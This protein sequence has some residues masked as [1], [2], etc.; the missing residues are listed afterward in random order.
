MF[1]F[2]VFFVPIGNNNYENLSS[3]SGKSIIDKGYQGSNCKVTLQL[4]SE[5]KNLKFEQNVLAK[6][7]RINCS[8]SNIFHECHCFNN[9]LGIRRLGFKVW[10]KSLTPGFALLYHFYEMIISVR[11]VD[12]W[13][14]L[15][16]THLFLF[17][18]KKVAEWS[19][20]QAGNLRVQG[21][22]SRQPLTPAL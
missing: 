21:S 10:G 3:R 4:G 6:E 8:K 14:E 22:N 18:K 1:I 17:I 16:L 20:H 11:I 13:L 2:K 7:M 12:T 15:S 5:G 9:W 19:W